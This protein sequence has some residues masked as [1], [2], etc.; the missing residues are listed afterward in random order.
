MH[1]MFMKCEDIKFMAIA[2]FYKIFVNLSKKAVKRWLLDVLSVCGLNC[3][4]VRHRNER[5]KIYK[6][7]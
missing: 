3:I 7:V 1:G 6:L 2:N 5:K 4:L